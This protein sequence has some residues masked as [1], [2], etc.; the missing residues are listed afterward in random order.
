MCGR[1]SVISQGVGKLE[2]RLQEDEKLEDRITKPEE[3]LAKG[4][5]QILI[6]YAIHMYLW[7]CAMPPVY[8]SQMSDTAVASHWARAALTS[9]GFSWAIQCPD[10]MMTSDRLGQSCRIGSASRDTIVS[11]V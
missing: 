8:L 1:V 4:S 6:S 5:E 7:H 10:E 2:T 3:K 11:Q 9:T